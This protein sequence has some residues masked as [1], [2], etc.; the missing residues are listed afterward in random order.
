MMKNK[1][2][3]HQKINILITDPSRLM[4]EAKVKRRCDDEIL[5]SVELG[6]DSG[7]SLYRQTHRELER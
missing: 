1:I 7:R 4:I 5:H 3:S 2:I 6:E